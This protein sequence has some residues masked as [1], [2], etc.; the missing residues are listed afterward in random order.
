MTI[1]WFSFLLVG[2]FAVTALEGNGESPL[3]PLYRA[4]DPNRVANSYIVKFKHES[5]DFDI[6]QHWQ[7][8]GKD[9]SSAKGFH[10]FPA[11]S[12]YTAYMASH[13]LSFPLSFEILMD[14][15]LYRIVQ[16]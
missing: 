2:A 11:T 3:A 8:I 13:L 7:A 5:S 12:G 10:Y 16:P 1:F 9:L 14:D 6:E 15:L 4:A